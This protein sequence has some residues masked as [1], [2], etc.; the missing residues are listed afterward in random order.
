MKLWKLAMVVLMLLVGTAFAQQRPRVVIPTGSTGGVFFFYGQAIAKILS[1]AGVADATAQQT[2][3][4]YD[5]LLLLRDRTDP[6]SNTYYC[7][8]ATTDSALVTY[9]GEEPRFAQRKADMQ[10]IMFYM[11]PSLIHIV[12][13]EKSGIKF[14]GDLRGK[15]VSTGQPGSST[16][17]LALLVLKGAG[18]DVRE[19]AKR[20]RLPAAESA[21]ALSEGTIDAYFWV[22][23]VPTSSVVELAQSLARK[24]DQIKLVDSPRTGP[25]AQ[26]LLKEFP[27]IITTGRLPKSAYGTKDDVFALFTGN[28]FLCP[29]S[30]PDDLA[31]AIMKAVFSNLQTLVTTTAAA[32]D[33]T[34]KNTVDLY[35]QKMVVPFHPGAVR[36]LREVGA[37]R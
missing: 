35:N 34:I 17:N 14:V 4:S 15:R 19:F 26:L 27:G 18:V 1:E 20:E 28:V 37:I 36:Y 13:T 6:R 33:T 31:A 3:G 23:G 24:G 8:L 29:A 9:T 5:N 10:R 21:K 22:G 16:E 7:A 25:T 2:G 32:R 12:T 30:M 11:Y